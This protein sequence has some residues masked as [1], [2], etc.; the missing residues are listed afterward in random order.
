MQPL[1]E[2]AGLLVKHPLLERMRVGSG[3][4]RGLFTPLLNENLLY[5]QHLSPCRPQSQSS[6][7]SEISS[8]PLLQ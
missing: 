6:L 3:V 4:R 8:V 1:G 5:T 7:S 2:Y